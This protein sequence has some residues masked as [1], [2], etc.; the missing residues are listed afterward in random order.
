ML[1]STETLII[2]VFPLN[3]PEVDLAVYSPQCSG[4]GPGTGGA[5]GATHWHLSI[6]KN[7]SLVKFVVDPASFYCVL[8]I[9]HS[10]QRREVLYFSYFR[11]NI[12]SLSSEVWTQDKTGQWGLSAGEREGVCLLSS[13]SHL[14][15]FWSPGWSSDWPGSSHH[16]WQRPPDCPHLNLQHFSIISTAGQDTGQT[17][18]QG[19]NELSWGGIITKWGINLAVLVMRTGRTYQV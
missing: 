2:D 14:A 15:L 4:V 10:N 12:I 3:H 13:Q 9:F 6:F 17:G 16:S 18:Q 7:V 1:T 8:P 11:P 19:V 5:G